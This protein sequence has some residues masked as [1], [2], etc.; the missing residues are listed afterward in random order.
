[1][2][3]NSCPIPRWVVYS[4][5]TVTTDLNLGRDVRY[6]HRLSTRGAGGADTLVR[7][8]L[9]ARGHGG[10]ASRR[11]G[12]CVAVGGVGVGGCMEG[13]RG[14]GLG[15]RGDGGADGG[16]SLLLGCRFGGGLLNNATL[17]EGVVLLGGV[18]LELV[19]GLGHSALVLLVDH[20]SE[21]SELVGGGS[22]I[23]RKVVDHLSLHQVNVAEVVKT[24]PNNSPALVRVGVVA[25][26]FRADHEGGKKQTVAE[27]AGSRRITGF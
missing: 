13:V 12:R 5:S 18:V 1:M 10:G 20:S 14:R 22:Q 6:R 7:W 4:R 2:L 3:P 9:W 8:G 17:A 19:G 26:H 21:L 16:E 23:P 25:D 27:S 11:V 24:R 15:G